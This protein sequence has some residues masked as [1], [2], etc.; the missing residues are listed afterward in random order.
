LKII[1][2]WRIGRIMNTK[3]PENHHFWANFGLKKLPLAT[4]IFR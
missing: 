4:K 1:D 2:P 3:N